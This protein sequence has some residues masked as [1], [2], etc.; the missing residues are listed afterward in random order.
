MLTECSTRGGC[1][2]GGKISTTKS[3]HICQQWS[4]QTPHRHRLY[5]SCDFPGDNTEDAGN[6]CRNPEPRTHYK[7]W[8]FTMHTAVRWEYCDIPSCGEYKYSSY[9]YV[10]NL[11]EKC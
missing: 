11:Q 7:P 8:C 4:S 6:L 9:C 3:G 1:E 2:Y 5:E 10:E